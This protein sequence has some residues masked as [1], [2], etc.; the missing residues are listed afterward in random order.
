M[1]LTEISLL[2]LRPY[3]LLDQD[4]GL[5]EIQCCWQYALLSAALMQGIGKL[6]LDYQ[7]EIHDTDG[8]HLNRWNPFLSPLVFPG[9]HYTCQV[10]H[11][12]KHDYQRRLNALLAERIMPEEG[13]TW[14]VSHPSVFEV[15]LALLDEEVHGSRILESILTRAED[16]ILAKS[17]ED[18]LAKLERSKTKSF[19]TFDP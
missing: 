8:E 9:Y 15:W 3:L 17:I 10:R 14:L 4:A 18:L 5:A 12:S 6:Y 19:L 16:V 7:I 13:F 2:M 1:R 11:E